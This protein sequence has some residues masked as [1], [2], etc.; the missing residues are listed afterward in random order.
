MWQFLFSILVFKKKK[1]KKRSRQLSYSR[2]L[3]PDT[4]AL[5]DFLLP[6]SGTKKPLAR[7]RGPHALLKTQAK[8]D[9]EAEEHCEPS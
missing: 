1:R 9:Q 6:F 2:L 3:N 7:T 5:G 8:L 4:H